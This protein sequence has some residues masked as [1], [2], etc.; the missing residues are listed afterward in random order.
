MELV[1]LDDAKVMQKVQK[2]SFKKYIDKYGHFED[3][4][5][6]MSIS[7]MRFNIGY[8]LGKYYKIIENDVIIGGIFGFLLDEEDSMK[9]AQFYILPE[10]QHKGIGQ[11]ALAFFISSQPQIN[12]WVADTIYQEQDN[13]NFYQKNGFSVIDL[14]EYADNLSFATL[15]RKMK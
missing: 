6:D 10:Y 15:I 9:I 3:N 12:V 7:R 14:E 5:Y 4:P 1:T 13:M 11:E 8:R 2:A